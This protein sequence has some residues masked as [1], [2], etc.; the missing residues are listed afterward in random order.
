MCVVTW[1]TAATGGTRLSTEVGDI[2]HFSQMTQS[3]IEHLSV[4]FCPIEVVEVIL[5]RQK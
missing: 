4:H 5:F 2:L 3:A 1:S